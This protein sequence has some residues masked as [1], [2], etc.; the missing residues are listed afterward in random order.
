MSRV[1]KNTLIDEIR[2]HKTRSQSNQKF[3]EEF[4]HQNNHSSE[5]EELVEE[6]WKIYL[7][8]KALEKVKVKFKG[9]AIQVFERSMDG[10]DADTIASQLDLKKNTVYRLKKRVQIALREEIQALQYLLEGTDHV[11]S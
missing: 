2:S 4:L 6:E 8:H 3:Q 9:K 1:I 5:L 11:S 10:E 7:T